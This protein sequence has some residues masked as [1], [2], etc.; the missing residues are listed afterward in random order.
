MVTESKAASGFE[1]Q[2]SAL[3]KARFPFLYISTWEEERVLASICAVAEDSTLVHTPR[4]VF[5]WSQTD[6][7]SSPQRTGGDETKAPLLALDFIEEFSEPAVFVL[8]DFHAFF[9]G[10]GRA[11]DFQV[12]RRIRDLAPVLKHS[13]VPKVAI[14]VS[15]VLILPTELQKDVEIVDFDLPSFDEIRELLADMI[16]ANRATGRIMIDL[17]SDAEERV[18]KAALGLTLQE[19][20]NAF[21]R[22]MVIDGRLD[23]GDVDVILEEK[24]QTIKKTEILEFVRTDVR[25]N[26]VGGLENLKRWL[27]KR[28]GSWLDAARRYCLPPP[29]GVLITGVPGCGKSLIAKA[30]SDTWQLPLLRLDVGRIFSGLVGSSEE[31]MRKAIKTAEAIAP[32]ILWIDEIEKGLSTGSSA[33]DSGTSARVFGTFL[34]WMQEKD[35]PVFVV[36]TSNNIHALPPE[37]LRKGRFDEIF[38]VDLPT[39]SERVNIFD[40][41]LRKRLRNPEVVGTFAVSPAVLENLSDLSEGF[42][43]AEIEQVVIS[44]LF[45]AFYEQRSITMDDLVKAIR[46]TVPLSITQAEQIR[47]IREWANVRAVAATAAPDRVAYD[48]VLPMAPAPSHARPG[49]D[50][51]VRAA[52]GGRAVDF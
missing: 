37:L 26:D 12:V 41:H 43:G 42:I 29:K 13:P 23:V 20:E 34:T 50:E 16:E 38:F 24:R 45:D 35:V 44:A 10:Q 27:T 11:P 32:S 18:A 14:F 21:A 52:R 30:I 33:G 22:A 46:T 47:S 1:V 2:L 49:A 39:R 19:A 25:M 6:G 4:T 5:S 7:M 31:N 36:A 40:L 15:P 28:N 3:L 51:D 8:K 17:E 9:G 48:T